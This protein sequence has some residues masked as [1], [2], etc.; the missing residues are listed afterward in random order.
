MH[1]SHTHNPSTLGQKS[2]LPLSL[3]QHQQQHHAS[4]HHDHYNYCQLEK[5]PT[6][7]DNDRDSNSTQQ[8]E[9]HQPTKVVCVNLSR[10]G[11][12]KSEADFKVYRSIENHSTAALTDSTPTTPPRAQH[13]QYLCLVGVVCILGHHA[14]CV[15]SWQCR[16]LLWTGSAS[17]HVHCLCIQVRTSM[18]VCGWVCI[19]DANLA[20]SSALQ[21][22]TH[23]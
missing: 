11:R 19:N 6:K 5:K 22:I 15:V 18:H 23:L 8:Q 3:L 14:F 10:F 17:C 2:L 20:V 12:P 7:I 9:A 4:T 16:V 1:P 13:T 21:H